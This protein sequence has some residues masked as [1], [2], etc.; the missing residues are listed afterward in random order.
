[1]SRPLSRISAVL[2]AVFILAGLALGVLLLFAVGAGGWFGPSAIELRASFQDVSGIKPGTVVRING[3]VAGQVASIERGDRG[4]GTVV[5]V[6]RLKA[7]YR[8]D[9]RE[10]AF[11]CIVN[12][13]LLATR[14]VAI[15]YHEEQSSEAPLLASGSTIPSGPSGDALDEVKEFARRTFGSRRVSG[16]SRS[17]F[18]VRAAFNDVTG[19]GEKAP[20]RIKGLPAGEVA[21]IEFQ[22]HDNPDEPP[23]VLCLNINESFRPYLRQG[24]TARIVAD[25]LLG[26][27]CVE[28]CVPRPPPGMLLSQLSPISPGEALPSTPS[29]DLSSAL[30]DLA[31]VIKDVREGKGTLGLLLQ[32]RKA[33][34]ALLAFLETSGD[35]ARRGK[36][37]LASIQRSSDAISKVPL[38]GGYVEEAPVALLVRA[39]SERNERVFAEA[40]LFEPNRAVLTK[41]GKAALDELGDWL[42][43]LRHAGSDVVVVSYADPAKSGPATQE[44]TR[45]Q[46]QAVADYIK[47]KHGAHKLGG[48]GWLSGNRKVTALGMGTAKAPLPPKRRL[49]AS[50]VEVIVFVP[51]E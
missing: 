13:G 3:R 33:Y 8:D 50:R 28:V 11:A 17:H 21:A 2:L 48:W 10:G 14:S 43:G 36:D 9:L 25:G 47:S 39:N 29:T 23:I 7:E 35:T 31:P 46:S 4:A 5:L 26:G 44:I 34:D 1:M 20:V 37:T 41:K 18:Q 51:Q 27:K 24:A 12:D 15:R 45:Q 40:E 30:A 6:M 19:V 22:P 38:I 42:T 16:L 32:D 49:P